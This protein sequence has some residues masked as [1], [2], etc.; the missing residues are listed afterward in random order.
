MSNPYA[1]L[2]EKQVRHIKV[3][4]LMGEV[5]ISQPREAFIAGWKAAHMAIATGVR[6]S[7]E[8][9]FEVWEGGRQK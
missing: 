5:G 3:R 1:G 7:P 9:A 4:E 6:L 2:S 8:A